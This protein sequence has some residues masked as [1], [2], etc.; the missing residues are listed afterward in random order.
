[1]IA[2]VHCQ[3]DLSTEIRGPILYLVRGRI[4]VPSVHLVIT[5]A[6]RRWVLQLMTRQKKPNT[7]FCAWVGLCVFSAVEQ[8]RKYTTWGQYY[9]WISFFATVRRPKAWCHRSLEAWLST[10][11]QNCF[12]KTTTTDLSES[13]SAAEIING[14]YSTTSTQFGSRDPVKNSRQILKA[15]RTHWVAY[16]SKQVA[17]FFWYWWCQR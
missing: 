13:S 9:R 7:L 8:C 6:L 15:W 5:S 4:E 1:M 2:H 11:T 17:S 3:W 12:R 10:K 14:M 16:S